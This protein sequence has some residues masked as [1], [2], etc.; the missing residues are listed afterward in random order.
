MQR[1]SARINECVP[2]T[3]H[4]HV[5]HSL[6]LVWNSA[7]KCC[8][9][10][11]REYLK[12]Q[13]IGATFFFNLQRNIITLLHVLPSTSNIVTQQNFVVC[14]LKNLLKKSRRSSTCC[15]MLLQLA[16]TKFCCVTM[17]EVGGNTRNNAFQLASCSNLLLV[18]LHLY[19]DLYTTL[20]H[21][22]SYLKQI[23]Q[24]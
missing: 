21:N 23:K 24:I 11:V 13:Y 16:T 8:V 3:S 14:T 22:L 12:A 19:N 17:F 7:V 1:S 20:R 18:L 4:L 9:T 5:N 2:Y 6:N 15:N 10:V